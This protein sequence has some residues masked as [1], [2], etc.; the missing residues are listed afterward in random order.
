M[1]EE[2]MTQSVKNW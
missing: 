2:L 1:V